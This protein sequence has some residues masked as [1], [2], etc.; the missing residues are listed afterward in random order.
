MNDYFKFRF[1]E[2]IITNQCLVTKH[3]SLHNRLLN[4]CIF[5]KMV[6]GGPQTAQCVPIGLQSVHSGWIPLQLCQRYVSLWNWHEK[7]NQTPIAI[8]WFLL[9]SKTELKVLG[10]FTWFLTDLI[11]LNRS[12]SR[13]QTTP[14]VTKTDNWELSALKSSRPSPMTQ[15]KFEAEGL[16]GLH[17]VVVQ[18]LG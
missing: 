13:S 9:D 18:R 10:R 1:R 14:T 8:S 15:T 4:Q 17:S 16:L 3:N 2:Y 7:T 6:L 12:S 5:T 11:D